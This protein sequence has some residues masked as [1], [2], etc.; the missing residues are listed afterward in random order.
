MTYNSFIFLLLFLPLSI[1]AYHFTPKRFKSKTLLIFS[2]VFY[3]LLS[4]RLITYLLLISLTSYLA[5]L[6]IEKTES[7]RIRNVVLF[8]GIMI[9]LSLLLWFKYYNFFALN[10]NHLLAQTYFAPKKLI[11]PIGISFFTLQ[12]IS[13]LVDVKNKK[14]PADKNPLNILLFLSFFPTIIEGPIARYDQVIP[15]LKANQ[16]IRYENLSFGL[17]RVLWGLIKKVVVA[18]RIDPFVMSVFNNID[19]NSGAILLSGILLYTL[20]LYAEFSGTMDIVI[21]IGQIFNVNLP[22]NFN[23]PFMAK[24]VS[25]FWRRWHMTLGAFFKDYIFYPISL[26]SRNRKLSK[27]LKKPLGKYYSR[28]LPSLI[29]LFAVWLAN[30]LWHGAQWQYILYGMYYFFLISLGILCE[31][32]ITAFFNKTKI[33]R[34]HK[35]LNVFRWI[36][37][38]TLVN[39]GMMIFRS[40]GVRNAIKM[41]GKII[42]DFEVV[43]IWDGSILGKGLDVYDFK[44][45][46]FCLILM[47]IV[48]VLKEKNVSIRARIATWR[49]PFR[50]SFYY[51]AM[52]FLIIF[53]AYG[54]GYAIVELIYANF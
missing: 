30:G 44:L 9:P 50:F 13:Y 48:G 3:F 51:A 12:A 34:E 17:Q 19:D 47:I 54:F 25:E 1:L 32:L 15:A 23:Q 29:A 11:Q 40:H 2:M 24:S 31:P 20:Q 49:L 46:A 4:D 5:G 35:V 26:S 38:F 37:T 53:G 33:K 21:G 16:S 8:L 14:Y 18:D 42:S 36:R 6:V 45:L 43:T 28:A 7:K 41:L 39:I 27:K 10:M 22:E 52:L